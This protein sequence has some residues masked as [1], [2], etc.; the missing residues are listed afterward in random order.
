MFAE[1]MHAS[2]WTWVLV[3]FMAVVGSAHAAS[4]HALDDGGGGVAGAAAVAPEFVAR[5]A[6]ITDAQAHGDGVTSPGESVY[7]R[8]SLR[9]VGAVDA[10]NTRITLATDDPDIDITEHA[11]QTTVWQ[12]GIAKER[13]WYVTIAATAALHDVTAIVAVTADNGGPWRFIL[14][15]PIAQAPL[16]FT[17][18]DDR[19]EDPI[20]DGDGDD[21]AEPGERVRVGVRLRNDGAT[22]ASDVRVALR[23]LDPDVSPVVA[24]AIHTTWPA[25]EERDTVFVVDIAP[26]AASHTVSLFISVVVDGVDPWQYSVLLPIVGREPDFAFRNS[27][28]FDPAPG[29]NRDGLATPGERVLPRVRL[30]NVGPGDAQDVEVRLSTADPDIVIA[31]GQVTHA[32]WT[33]GSARNNSGFVIDIA[34]GATAR[35]TTL[36]ATVT[37]AGGG[38]WE[39]TIP[40]AIGEARIEIVAR[41]MWLFDPEPHGNRDGTANPGERALPVIRL[42][43]N[44]PSAVRNVLVAL[45]IDDPAVTV[46]RGQMS[47]AR[48]EPG[49]AITHNG[50]TVSIESDASPHDVTA[51]VRVTADDGGPW[52]FP[53]V[54]PIA[55]RPVKF[56]KRS[57]W[58]FDPAP[59]GDRDGQ[60][61]A[62]E[63]VLPRIR[64]RNVGAEE[65]R[66]VRVTLATDDPEVTIVAGEVTHGTW[67]AGEARNNDGFIM[68]IA[69]DAEGHDVTVRATVR[70]DNGGPWVLTYSIP[71][72]APAV[73]F[74]FQG[75]QL[76][77]VEARLSG[78]PRILLRHIGTEPL[79]NVRVTLASTRPEL[80]VLTAQQ[81]YATWLPG[82]TRQT[83]ELLVHG[84]RDALPRVVTLVASVTTVEGGLWQFEFNV[85][86]TR[87][88]AFLVRWRLMTDPSPGG[89]AD[90]VMGPGE[91]VVPV[92]KIQNKSRADSINVVTTLTSDDPDITVVSGVD[93]FARWVASSPR[94]LSDYALHIAEDATAHNALMHLTMTAD[95]GDPVR[96]TFSFSIVTPP[97]EFER[98][99]AWIWDLQ[100][101][102]NRDGQANPGERVF[103]RVRIRN[104]GD[105]AATNVHAV[106]SLADDDITVVN[107]IVT[108]EVWPGGEARNNNGFVIDIDP[109][110]TPHDVQAVLS[111]TADGVRPWQFPVTIAIVAPEAVATAL[112]ANYPNP[113]NPETWIPFDLSEPADVTVTVY[114][115][116]GSVVRLIDLGRLNPGAYRGRDDA[117]YWDGRNDIGERVSSGAYIYELRAGAHREMRRMIVRK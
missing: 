48:W 57:A 32:T 34:P 14:T 33:A 74:A 25:G 105:G 95:H 50:F 109:E 42:V 75:A 54:F 17:K 30:R 114:D 78:R 62:G 39:F 61:E 56:L 44:G 90:G 71:V 41:R 27:W 55:Y 99:N 96:K 10:M 8:I 80:T 101:G 18:A 112:L 70:A 13:A 24:E 103:P 5:S 46:T 7:V 58:V 108:H 76:S 59:G 98:R 81:V 111:V 65:A 94:T 116:R 104:V 20:P 2:A 40:F 102:A 68:S 6:W 115:A 73:G 45:E 31:Q 52:D 113:F 92:V 53:F 69:P 37:A 26:A 21:V 107:G 77:S 1:R 106:L 86:V 15:F 3:A 4:I 84:S 23:T 100:P 79:Q 47:R 51:T 43:N 83:T 38:S 9:N 35:D 66:N 16:Y 19:I 87:P 110:A 60:A 67:P 72:V 93:T 91:T 11:F 29:G 36:V 63:R 97:P 82:E 49:A 88:I 64:L 28:L 117:A 89:N 12:A 22:D 85:A